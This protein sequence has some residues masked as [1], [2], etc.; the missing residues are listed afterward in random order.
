MVDY[1]NDYMKSSEAA[2]KWGITE[3]RV[4]ILC[5]RNKVDSCFKVGKT[6]FI[7]KDAPKPL[8]GRT[9]RLFDKVWRL[10]MGNIDVDGLEELRRLHPL[11]VE[12]MKS[13]NF[14]MLLAKS[15]VFH[16]QDDEGAKSVTE[17]QIIRIFSGEIVPS[18]SLKL[19]LIMSHFYYELI[20]TL[21][22]DWTPTLYNLDDLYSKLL[23]CTGEEALR[24]DG[25][26]KISR[27][28]DN[29]LSVEQD[30]YRLYNYY[31]GVMVDM[32]PVAMASI[33]YGE[34][35]RIE[36]YEKLRGLI[37]FFALC[38]ILVTHGYIPPL[39][40]EDLRPELVASLS[41]SCNKG[42]YRPLFDF[43]DR[44][45]KSAYYFMDFGTTEGIESANLFDN[46]TTT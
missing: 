36:P 30:F 12:L 19:H 37:C 24:R 42:N 18:L 5:E 15:I 35:V 41:Q 26:S 20:N 14:K 34:M 7:P 2:E 32:D 45:M 43:I 10:R 25:K 28:A 16:L 8:D 31:K 38:K 11:T 44:A 17:K 1:K 39:F 13:E 27:N 22:S 46:F 9:G 40:K 3:R 33:F 29:F 23:S 21:G 6:W 4:R